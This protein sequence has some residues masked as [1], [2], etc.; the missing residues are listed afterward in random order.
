MASREQATASNLVGNAKNK[1][2][3]H[4]QNGSG[5]FCLQVLLTLMLS[6]QPPCSLCLCG[7]HLSLDLH[8]RDTENTEVAES[9]Y[10]SC[11]RS[12]RNPCASHCHNSYDDIYTDADGD[13]D[14]VLPLVVEGALVTDH[15]D[16]SERAPDED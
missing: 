16:Y 3:S 1:S 13:R 8:H 2:R 15:R 11:A 10:P 4:F 14:P 7:G 12:L 5:F 9:R 6:V